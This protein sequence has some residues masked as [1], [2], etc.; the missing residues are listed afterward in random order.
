MDIMPTSGNEHRSLLL[1]SFKTYAVFAP[2]LLP[3]I[4]AIGIWSDWTV[5]V[6][7]FFCL[8]TS[9]VLLTVAISQLSTESRKGMISSFICAGIALFWIFIF[10]ILLPLTARAK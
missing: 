3:A 8:M 1:I 9:A 5:H 7:C 2:L 4:A 10:E 6:V